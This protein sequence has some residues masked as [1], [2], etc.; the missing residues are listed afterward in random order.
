MKVLAKMIRWCFSTWEEKWMS[1]RYWLR[2]PI[3]LWLGGPIQGLIWGCFREEQSAMVLPGTPEGE[4]L[5][6]QVET[7]GTPLF[8]SHLDSRYS[9]LVVRGATEVDLCRYTVDLYFSFVFLA[10][11]TSHKFFM[12]G[13]CHSFSPRFHLSP[14]WAIKLALILIE[15]PLP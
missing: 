12:S 10:S 2:I 4:Q 6:G 11:S 5:W 14:P 13:W 9:F 8:P 7:L 3:L 1:A 15:P